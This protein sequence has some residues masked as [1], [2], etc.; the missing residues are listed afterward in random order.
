MRPFSRCKD[1]IISFA[2]G[3]NEERLMKREKAK[4]GRQGGSRLFFKESGKRLL[5]GAPLNEE[6]DYIEKETEYAG[7]DTSYF[8]RLRFFGGGFVLSLIP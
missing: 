5:S 1:N 6:H 4:E 2:G 7:Y 8:G 3:E